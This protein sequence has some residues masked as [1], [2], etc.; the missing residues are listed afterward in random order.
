MNIGDQ[1][2]QTRERK[3]LSLR[4]VGEKAGLSASF[5][6]QVERDETSPSMRSIKNIT[7]A[8]GVKLA[9]LLN[10]VESQQEDSSH[11]VAL[12]NRRK[13]ENLF[14]GLEMYYLT[15]KGKKDFM[16]AMLYAKP[17]SSSG[18]DFSIHDGEEFGY[19]ISGM[20]WFWMDG[21]EYNLREGDSIS[22]NSSV[23]HKWE[24]RSS[25]P[26]TSLWVTAPPAY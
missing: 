14:P 6:G 12:D 19:I 22:L 17:G 8:L 10:S 25:S 26:C 15:P 11:L 1:L 21:N 3:G 13:V 9:D 5:I 4:E 16:V 20:L 24:N 2:K 23:P 7:D 18:D